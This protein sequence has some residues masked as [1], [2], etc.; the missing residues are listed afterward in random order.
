MCG[1]DTVTNISSRPL[2]SDGLNYTYDMSH[3]DFFLILNSPPL[4]ITFTCI[5]NASYV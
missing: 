4:V 1:D 3:R 5:L 2:H